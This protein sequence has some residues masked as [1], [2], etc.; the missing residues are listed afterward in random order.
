MARKLLPP[1]ILAMAIS[2]TSGCEHETAGPLR[3][4]EGALAAL[5]ADYSDWSA[6][7]SI[8]QSSPGAHSSFNTASLDG[9][10]F[11]SRDGKTFYMAS[12]RPDGLGGID[13]WVSTRASVDDPWG[14]P[15][16]VGAPVN[17]SADDFC[18]TMDRDG[19]RF[20]FVSRRE[21]PGWCGG[22]D[23]YVTRL[24]NEGGFEEPQNL[25]CEVNSP[26]DEASPFPLAESG[27]G[28]VLY[29]SS[30]RPGLGVGGDLYVSESHGG[31]YGPARLV[32]GVNS[33][34][35]DGQPNVR[36]DGLELFFYSTR[37]GGGAPDLYAATRASTSDPWSTPVNLGPD[38]NSPAGETRPSLSW[39]GTTLYFGSN[40]AGSEGGSVDI[41]VATRERL[42][43]GGD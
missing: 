42:T 39:D 11:I 28:P 17:S 36:R 34:F 29:F 8:E 7:V 6:A 15:A 31:V 3:Q 1:A 13:I 35:D 18:P 27:S 16:N 26:F 9:C 25:G 21:I 40:R 41:Y 20:F 5:A 22:S 10:P 32:P 33:A 37:P 38:V 23:I 43:I 12:N 14:P 4:G 30:T 2:A 24:R 19:H